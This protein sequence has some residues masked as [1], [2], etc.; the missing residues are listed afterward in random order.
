M[1]WHLCLM[2]AF[3][4]SLKKIMMNHLLLVLVNFGIFQWWLKCLCADVKNSFAS[5]S[6]VFSFF[7]IW[8]RTLILPQT[9]KISNSIYSKTHTHTYIFINTRDA[10]MRIYNSTNV[11]IIL[12]QNSPVYSPFACT[13][14]CTYKIP[15][16]E[17][18]NN[19]I[20]VCLCVYVYVC[21]VH[22]GFHLLS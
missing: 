8:T 21:L 15:L 1:I 14:P 7:S 22:Y 18:Q 2:I 12:Y 13:Y 19:Q 6:L 20:S 3:L 5:C 9:Y 10:L 17:F 16:L 11:T 4:Y